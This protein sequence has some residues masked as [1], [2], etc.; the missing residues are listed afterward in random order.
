V[1]GNISAIGGYV[2]EIGQIFSS[3]TNQSNNP[4]PVGA[5]TLD[6][7]LSAIGNGLLNDNRFLFFIGIP[8]ILNGAISLPIPQYVPFLCHRV[9]LP[10]MGFETTPYRSNSYGPSQEAPVANKFSRITAFFYCDD[11]GVIVNFFNFWQSRIMF[12]TSAPNTMS[13]KD[14]AFP[15]ETYFKTEYAVNAQ[16]VVY[17]KTNQS[18]INY[19]VQLMWPSN[20][21]D[22]QLDWSSKNR[23]F[24]LP[25][26]FSFKTCTGISNYETLNSALNTNQGLGSSITQLG[27]V[28]TNLGQFQTFTKTTPDI[29]SAISSAFSIPKYL[30]V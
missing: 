17:S 7:F 11:S 28:V 22:V 21:G 12:N 23:Q 8:S 27:Q 9:N 15:F 1:V 5:P 2:S 4:N 14:G 18:I 3:L 19:D 30:G 26:T 25:V 16:L 29:V 24:V 10:G 20:I 6:Q 13:N